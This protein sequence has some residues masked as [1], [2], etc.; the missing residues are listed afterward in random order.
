MDLSLLGR[1]LNTRSKRD[2]TLEAVERAK[3]ILLELEN[4]QDEVGHTLGS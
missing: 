2:R 4:L 1:L 3:K